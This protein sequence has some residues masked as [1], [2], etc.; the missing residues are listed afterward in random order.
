MK[1]VIED[2]T[3]AF[4]YGTIAKYGSHS[5]TFLELKEYIKNKLKILENNMD[6]NLK[7][8]SRNYWEGFKARNEAL[9]D[10]LKNNTFVNMVFPVKEVSEGNTEAILPAV[11]PGG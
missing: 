6:E 1:D 9:W 4:I 5:E 7:L 2:D 10:K 8:P 3:I 11:I